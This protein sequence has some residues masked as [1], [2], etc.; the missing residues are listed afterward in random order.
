MRTTGNISITMPV[1]LVRET[2]RLAKREN[3]TIS[4]L[5]REALRQYKANVERKDKGQN[6]LAQI[7][8]ILADAK[9]EPMTAKNLRAEEKR[10]LEYGARQA[11]TLGIK[12]RDVVR[13]IH[14]SR[15]GRRAS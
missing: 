12:E 3:R 11:K 6:D 2:A 13:I 4:G 1:A 8:T 10:L 5:L 9:S 14:E 15:A 7:A